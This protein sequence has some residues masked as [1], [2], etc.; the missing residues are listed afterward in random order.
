M[1]SL[2]YKKCQQP[3]VLSVD[4]ECRLYSN[5]RQI[6]CS[7]P[8]KVQDGG[9]KSQQLQELYGCFSP[10]PTI[11]S[12]VQDLNKMLLGVDEFLETACMCDTSIHVDLNSDDYRDCIARERELSKAPL[13]PEEILEDDFLSCNTCCNPFDELVGEEF[14]L[15]RTQ[16]CLR[17][18]CVAV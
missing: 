3:D 7:G 11:K 14:R 18:W 15:L 5:G 6:S 10:T 8:R 2:L 16:R 12:Y 17:S 4:E 1:N 13:K 9:V